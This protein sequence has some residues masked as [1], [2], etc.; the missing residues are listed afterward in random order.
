VHVLV[1]LFAY[2]PAGQASQLV[3]SSEVTDPT[4]HSKLQSGC[5]ASVLNE[6]DEHTEQDEAPAE[7]VLP[8]GQFRHSL[9]EEKRP[10]AQGEQTEAK[11]ELANPGW[12]DEQDDEP[13]LKAT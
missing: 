1:V 6:K 8:A 2:D 4:S 13:V 12:Q 10:A 11:A 5:P 9:P 3:P 7:L